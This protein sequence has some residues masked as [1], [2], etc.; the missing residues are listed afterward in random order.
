MEKMVI[1]SKTYADRYLL[2]AFEQYIEH[3]CEHWRFLQGL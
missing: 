3:A 2:D 1:E